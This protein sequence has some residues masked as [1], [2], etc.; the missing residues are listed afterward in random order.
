MAKLQRVCPR[1]ADANSVTDLDP[2]SPTTFDNSYFTNLLTNEGLLIT[3]Q[4]L[5]STPGSP[6]IDPVKKF[7]QNQALFFSHFVYSMNKMGNIDPLTGKNGEIRK[8]C[9]KVNNA[10]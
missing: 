9:R 10:N 8:N 5:Y 4:D 6:T 2:R 7:S 3:D 1:N